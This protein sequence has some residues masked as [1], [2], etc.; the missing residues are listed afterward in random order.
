[1]IADKLKPLIQ[2]D[3]A[4]SAFGIVI[5]NA[6]TP[7]HTAAQSK[8]NYGFTN[9]AGNYGEKPH[10]L[11]YQSILKIVR[12]TEAVTAATLLASGSI[13]VALV[14]G[15][16]GALFRN[17]KVVTQ[18]TLMT[19]DIPVQ[20]GDIVVVLLSDSQAGRIPLYRIAKLVGRGQHH[21]LSVLF[22]NV[23]SFVATIVSDMPNYLEGAVT[24]GDGNLILANYFSIQGTTILGQACWLFN[25]NDVSVFG[26][27]AQVIHIKHKKND[28]AIVGE[29]ADSEIDKGDSKDNIE[30][31]TQI[32]DFSNLEHR[33]IMVFIFGEIGMTN[34]GI[35]SIKSAISSCDSSAELQKTLNELPFHPSTNIMAAFVSD[36]VPPFQLEMTSFTTNKSENAVQADLDTHCTSSPTKI[37]VTSSKVEASAA[38]EFTKPNRVSIRQ[39]GGGVVLIFNEKVLKYE[40]QIA[41]NPWRC[42]KLEPGQWIADHDDLRVEPGDTVMVIVPH[43]TNNHFYAPTE[44][45]A[46]VVHCED[47]TALLA[48]Y[49]PE[50]VATTI[51]AHIEK[52]NATT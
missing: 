33:D 13:V 50:D 12:G 49:L 21:Q 26:L 38:I 11:A 42:L 22:P 46:A 48:K 10:I 20:H 23:I 7:V 39:S 36:K 8:P 29:L 25:G 16:M 40:E 41:F 37:A 19:R 51:V 17:G 24:T 1:L 27:K 15:E 28:A 2:S 4:A 30:L 52:V 6:A 14:S 35:A 45:A 44:I 31:K 47:L 43:S 32:V 34:I 9:F 3:R 5:E 18:F